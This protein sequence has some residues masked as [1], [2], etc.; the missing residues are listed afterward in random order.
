MH[1][2]NRPHTCSSP[3]HGSFTMPDT[4]T[5]L[6]QAL[7]GNAHPKDMRVEDAEGSR[8][9]DEILNGGLTAWL[10][11]KGSFFLFFNTW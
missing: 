9:E 7:E 5:Q 2:Y 1:L 6:P 4:L 3:S 11:V 10:Q 8:K